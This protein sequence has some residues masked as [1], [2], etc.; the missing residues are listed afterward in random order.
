MLKQTNKNNEH[1]NKWN[2]PKLL[3]KRGTQKPN[4]L[5]NQQTWTWNHHKK[6]IGTTHTFKSFG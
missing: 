2:Y 5:N 3:L 1:E 6:K 4:E